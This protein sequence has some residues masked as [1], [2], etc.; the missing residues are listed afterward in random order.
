MG[1]AC[2]GSP[3]LHMVNSIAPPELPLLCPQF[4]PP[5]LQVTE[6][7]LPPRVKTLLA[8]DGA[9]GPGGAQNRG[10]RSP[11]AQPSLCLL[12]S[13]PLLHVLIEHSDPSPS[14]QNST[15]LPPT[16]PTAAQP[17]LSGERTFM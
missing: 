10:H 2:G 7:S 1:V 9:W 12:S 5:H 11:L 17:G 14:A 4:W 3:G 15:A 6:L 16:S 8:A 13:S